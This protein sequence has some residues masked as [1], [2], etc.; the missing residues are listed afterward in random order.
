MKYLTKEWY[1]LCQQISLHSG[2]RVHS[3]AHQL[4]EA[5]YLR[6]YKRKEKE[7]VK[8]QR[9]VYNVDP[10]YMLEQDGAVLVRAEKF[11]SGDEVTEED[12]MVYHM[13]P[14]EREH[15]EKLIADYD[16]RPPFD[17]LS[18]RQ[19]FKSNLEWNCENKIARLPKEIYDQI[20]DIRVFGLGY[21]TREVMRQLKKQSKINEAQMQLI[22]KEYREAQLAEP[23]PEHI[24]NQVHFHDCTVTELVSDTDLVI[25]FDTRGGFTNLNKVTFVAPEIIKQE[26]HIVRSYWLYHE[27]Y[28]IENGYEVHMLFDGAEMS[29]LIIQCQDIVVEEE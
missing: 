7:H 20:A 13:P 14:E 6:L 8:F 26:E 4:D 21:C 27:M 29:E 22:S 19:E 15:I 16:A 12:T 10:R 17:E 3:G 23:I 9:D 25:R 24:R 1:E 28:R 5:L 18:S 11:I 2:M